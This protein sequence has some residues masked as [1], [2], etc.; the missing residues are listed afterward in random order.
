[1]IVNHQNVTQIIE[2]LELQKIVHLEEAQEIVRE[3]VG[4]QLTFKDFTKELIDLMDSIADED[5]NE[6]VN[7]YSVP[8]EKIIR[9]LKKI[10][11]K[12][13][14]NDEEGMKDIDFA[15][16]KILE[17]SIY[18]VDQDIQRNYQSQNDDQKSAVVEW[19]DE[20][21]GVHSD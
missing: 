18:D 9:A 11:D 19:L 6:I 13:L 14:K 15:I 5:F 8:A 21:S 1:M 7:S 16:Q 4:E 3:Y 12:H 20:F 17:R 10:K 2:A